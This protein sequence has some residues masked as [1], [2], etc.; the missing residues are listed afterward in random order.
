MRAERSLRISHVGLRGV[1]GAGGLTASHVLDFAS[2]FATFL[3]TPGPVILGRDP[4]A[5][6]V[7]IREG[8]VA[9][10]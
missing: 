1:V 10:L 5:S 9:A 4:R 6:G 2:A 7:M 3:Q 8:V